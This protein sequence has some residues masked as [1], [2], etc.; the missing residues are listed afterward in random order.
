MCVLWGYS[1]WRNQDFVLRGPENR[2]AVGAEFETPKASSGVGIPLPSRLG[3]L[4][5]RRKLPQ[6]NPGRN[7][8]RK[9]ILVHFELEKNESGDDKF[10]IV[11][12]FYSAYLQSNLQG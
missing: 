11:C 10:D 8:G 2:G 6:R 1:H 3:G 4:E 9:Q 7:P 12:H 5:E